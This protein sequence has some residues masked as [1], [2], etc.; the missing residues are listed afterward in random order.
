MM[1]NYRG[2]ARAC[3]QRAKVELSR[4][5]DAGLRYAALELRGAIEALTYDRAL[6]YLVDLS[7]KDRKQWRPEELMKSL[8]E[9]D[10]NAD[11]SYTLS[12]GVEPAPG[13]RPHVMHSL[14]RETAFNLAEIRTHYQSISGYLHT[15]KPIDQESQS[16]ET[17]REHCAKVSLLVEQALGSPISNM[18]LARRVPIAC[19]CGE[20]FRR[21]IPQ[22]QSEVRAKCPKCTRQYVFTQ[23]DDVVRWE[24]MDVDRRCVKPDCDGLK[25]FP[26][27]RIEVGT[28]WKCDICKGSNVLTK[29]WLYHPPRANPRRPDAKRK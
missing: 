2:E 15:Q 21:H 28:E 14:G 29:M 17:L 4:P 25:V 5:D 26:S 22:G 13:E 27:D 10:Q 1:M 18:R 24:C 9:V 19:D 12:V 8:C 20:T 6:S 7:S 16:F 3:L 11:R 23:A